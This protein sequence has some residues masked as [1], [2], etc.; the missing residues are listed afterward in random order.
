MMVDVV[1]LTLCSQSQALGQALILSRQGSGGLVVS[2][3]VKSCVHAL[4][5]C[6]VCPINLCS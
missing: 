1:L 6:G 4:F 5:L 2:V 3:M